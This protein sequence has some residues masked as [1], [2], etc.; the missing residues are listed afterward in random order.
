MNDPGLDSTIGQ[1]ATEVDGHV[2]NREIES[3]D[4][5]ELGWADDLRAR[6]GDVAESLKPARWWIAST[7]IPLTAVR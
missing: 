3:T 6:E 5:P 7:A 1:E 2:H 4:G